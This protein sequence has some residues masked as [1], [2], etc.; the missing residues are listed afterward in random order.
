MDGG[1]SEAGGKE[2]LE[3][4]V[5]GAVNTTLNYQDTYSRMGDDELLRLASQ[6]DTLTEPAQAAVTAD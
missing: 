6:W 4:C 1:R 2:L 3:G 5:A